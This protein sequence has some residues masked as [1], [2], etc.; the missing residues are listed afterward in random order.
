[1][2]VLVMMSL[3]ILSGIMIASVE[4]F[5]TRQ[6]VLDYQLHYHGQAVNTAKAGLIDALSWFRRQTAQPVET[7]A[8]LRDLGAVPP[9]NETNDPYIGLVREY[10]ITSE[11]T[12]KAD[13]I[14]ARYEVRIGRTF[15]DLGGDDHCVGV[16]DITRI[17]DPENQL[18]SG[19]FWY[20][21]AKGI[22][23]QR[24]DP[25]NYLTEDFYQVYESK[26]GWRRKKQPDGSF[27]YEENG[28][29]QFFG[30]DRGPDRC[31]TLGQR[32]HGH[33]ASKALG[34]VSG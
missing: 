25:D 33:G 34:T 3:V 2:M 24:L 10:E 4:V 23:F 19:R 14:F 17:K 1:M 30:R 7:Y 32:Y 21:E 18:A 9:I 29:K 13:Q 28:S 12:A 5:K 22:I 16:Q 11:D 20:I 6:H 27:V 8:P 15:Q 26:D 31:K